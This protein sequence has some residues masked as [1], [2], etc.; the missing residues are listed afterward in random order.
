MTLRSY[1]GAADG[2]GTTST[3]SIGLGP[4]LPLAPVHLLALRGTSGDIALSWVRR[5]RADGDSWAGDDAPLDFAPEGYRV[6]I[7][8]G[9]TALRTIDAARP[10]AIYTAADQAEDFGTPPAAFDWTVAQLSVRFGPGHAATA[11]FTD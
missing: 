10:A 3:V 2:E 5:S 7:L 1:A 4:V 6:A 11:G 8:D 9:G